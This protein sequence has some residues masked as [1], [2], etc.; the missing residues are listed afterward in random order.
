[1]EASPLTPAGARQEA[2]SRRMRGVFLLAG[3]VLCLCG[4]VMVSMRGA[5]TA[6]DLL[7]Q[8]TQS[9]SATFDPAKIYADEKNI[10]QTHPNRIDSYDCLFSS[11]D[12]TGGDPLW[13]KVSRLKKQLAK[14]SSQQRAFMSKLDKPVQTTIQVLPGEPGRMGPRGFRG[15]TGPQ[16]YRGDTGPQGRPG[17][18]GR[19][20]LPGPEGDRGPRGPPGEMGDQGRQGVEGDRGP[21][22]PRG[23]NGPQGPAGKKGPKGY[24]GENGPAGQPGVEGN[25]G[26]RGLA[27]QGPQGPE[28]IAGPQGPP[29]EVG[30]TGLRGKAGPAGRPGEQGP[31]GVAGL[32]GPPGEDA[33]QAKPGQCPGMQ[34]SKGESICCGVSRTDWH[35]YSSNGAVMTINTEACKFS[36]SVRYFTGMQGGGN[37]F[38]QTGLNTIYSQTDKSFTIYFAA[39]R[40]T[41]RGWVANARRYKISWC[42]VGKSSGP[43]VA[44][45]CCGQQD[46]NKWNYYTWGQSYID[47][48]AS[49]C[50]MRGTPVWWFGIKGYK[51][52]S[53]KSITGVSAIYGSYGE[54]YKRQRMY[55]TYAKGAGVHYYNIRGGKPDEIT[56]NYC[57]FG[58]PF[59]SGDAM[60]NQGYITKEEYP[61][62]GVRIVSKYGTVT[63]NEGKV[64]CGDSKVDWAPM[65]NGAKMIVDT[66]ACGFS[67]SKT[68][69]TYMTEIAGNGNQWRTTGGAAIRTSDSKS[70]ELDLEF[71]PNPGSTESYA[72]QYQWKIQWCGIGDIP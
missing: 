48:D 33:K 4:A 30:P 38:I 58:S 68:P 42:G 6:D 56:P 28:G 34:T 13:A 23:P 14:F 11:C 15:K 25:K 10:D 39:D 19:P 60:M 49:A 29:G 27:P 63:T 54:Q 3:T 57:V 24:P 12:D 44:S 66:S 62:Q 65:T 35:D 31:P 64:C 43:K 2:S 36:G 71:Q 47:I 45:M 46:P 52:T 22:G 67:D 59:P 70:F 16:G 69:I 32:K 9:L 17:L 61:C 53:P 7:Q 26:P 37:Q 5:Q 1:M 21:E 51:Q 20:G 41:M 50:E 55:L 18:E 40:E 72:D 8:H